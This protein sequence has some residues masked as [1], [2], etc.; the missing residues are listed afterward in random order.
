MVVYDLSQADVIVSLESDFLN[1]GPAMLA[2]ARQFAGR[3]SVDNGANPCRLYAIESSPS[4][5]GSLADHRFPVKSSAIPAVTYQL[6]KACGVAA[7][8]APGTAPDWLNAVVTDLTNAKGRSVVVP[9]EFQPESVHLAAYA[10]NAALGN[11]GK[12]VRVMEGV[13]PDQTHSL[14][15]LTNDLN[16]GRVETLLILGG[17]P[18]YTAPQRLGFA[19]AIKKARLVI[20]LGQ[21]FDETSRWSHWHIPETHYLETWSDSPRIRWHRDNPAAINS[22]VV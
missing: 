21:F 15:E 5:S 2:Y 17:N 6:A 14:D 13:E 19:E 9:G 4:V 1:T 10:I 8:D 3:R 20:R 16:N 18:V 22:A 12:T 11:V 7:P